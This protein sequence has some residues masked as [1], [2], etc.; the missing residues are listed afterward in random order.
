MCRSA[1]W[2]DGCSASCL[3]QRRGADRA[4]LTLAPQLGELAEAGWS[5]PLEEIV[6]AVT[7][8]AQASLLTGKTP[9]RAWHRRQWL[10]VPRHRRGSVLAAIQPPVPGRA[11]LHDGAPA[12]ARARPLVPAAK[13]F[14]WFNQGAAV[15]ISVTPKPHY[16]ADG[17]KVFG[18]TGTPDGLTDRLETRTGQVSLPHLLGAGRGPA[19]HRSGSPGPR[20]M[21]STANGPT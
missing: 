18:I 16:G 5:S 20:P 6:P 13:L 7:C 10:A 4:L 15:D 17:N 3:D 19:L 1:W 11:D 21:S 9:Q 12:G 8:T 14:W 2:R